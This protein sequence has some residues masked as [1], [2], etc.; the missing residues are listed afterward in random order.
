MAGGGYNGGMEVVL[1]M[2]LQ[3]AG[4]TTFYQERFAA[5]HAYVSR[6]CLR[7]HRRPRRRE[8]ELIRLALAEGRSVVVDNTH[9]AAADRA[10]I[11][12]LAREFGARVSGYF[13]ESE[14]EA[15][16]ERNRQREGKARVPEVALYTT[17]RA[18][19][20]PRYEEG[21]DELRLVRIAD[22]GYVIEDWG[23]QI[24]RVPRLRLGTHRSRGS[25]SPEARR[26]TDS[27]G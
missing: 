26:E 7:N 23:E 1:L 13:L 24:T 11:I 19:E 17:I 3:G 12:A 6:D 2:G 22:G 5:T 4:K 15:C 14:L 21:F 18:F 8:Q 27:S 9:P 20:L 25:A 16:L 10:P